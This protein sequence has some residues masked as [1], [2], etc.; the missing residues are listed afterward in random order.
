MKDPYLVVCAYLVVDDHESRN[1]KYR[2]TW[3]IPEDEDV[4]GSLGDMEYSESQLATSTSEDRDCIVAYLAA[5]STE[6]AHR[7]TMGLFWET[8]AKAR[9]A[10]RVVKAALKADGGPPMPEWALKAIAEG[11]KAPKGWRP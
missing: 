2:L 10:L 9:A 3:Y 11:W 4:G 5:K 6:G 7:D 1:W 8:E